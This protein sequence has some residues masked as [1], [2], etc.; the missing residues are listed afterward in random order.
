LW[1]LAV[2][3]PVLL[4]TTIDAS[5]WHRHYVIEDDV[6]NQTM[7]LVRERQ[8]RSVVLRDFTGTLGDIFVYQS[9]F[10]EALSARGLRITAILCTPLGVDRVGSVARRLG[11]QTSPRCEDTPAPPG[12]LLLDASA[13]ASRDR[14]TVSPGTAESA[15]PGRGFSGSE[16]GASEVWWWMISPTGIIRV[17]GEPAS[18]VVVS[19]SLI[20]PPCG[21][22]QASVNGKPVQ[23]TGRAGIEVPVSIDGLGS[24]AVSIAVADEP[25]RTNDPRD[26]FVAVSNPVLTVARPGDR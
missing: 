22:V 14:T 18:T 1:G 4:T 3:I 19:L 16:S 21:Q 10:E 2:A 6:L 25:C 9:V 17:T 5:G 7:N 24:G 26:L 13:S 11:T 12:A 15:T 23:V 8:A 20:A